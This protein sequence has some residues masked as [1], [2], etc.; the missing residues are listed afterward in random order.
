MSL[1][2]LANLTIGVG[3]NPLTNSMIVEPKRVV[4]YMGR[5]F[6]KFLAFKSRN[7]HFQRNIGL[8]KEHFPRNNTLTAEHMLQSAKIDLYANPDLLGVIS[9]DD[10]I[11][12]TS[13]VVKSSV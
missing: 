12:E 3:C 9:Y 4:G 11:V 1:C 13:R 8:L 2:S 7:C 6:D 10:P 5:F